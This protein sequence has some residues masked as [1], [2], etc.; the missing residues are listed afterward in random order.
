M[1]V[2]LFQCHCCTSCSSVSVIRGKSVQK[3]LG[4]S[5]GTWNSSVATV[6][7]VLVSLAVMIR[8]H[9]PSILCPGLLCRRHEIPFG[10]F[11]FQTSGTLS[12]P[13]TAFPNTVSV[14]SFN[15]DGSTVAFLGSHFLVLGNHHLCLISPNLVSTDCK[16]TGQ[17]HPSADVI[18]F[19]SQH[20][21]PIMKIPSVDSY[22]AVLRAYKRS[23]GTP[24]Y[25]PISFVLHHHLPCL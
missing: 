8:R 22:W 11:I 3:T 12:P 21:S 4:A 13:Q 10:H 23:F 5:C 24:R 1:L 19:S 17:L 6:S 9:P 7:V 25:P 16:Y 2:R 20:D 15:A 14:R 18:P